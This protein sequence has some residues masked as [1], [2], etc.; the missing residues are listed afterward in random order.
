MDRARKQPVLPRILALLG[1]S[2]LSLINLPELSAQTARKPSPYEYR[3]GTAAQPSPSVNDAQAPAYLARI[4]SSDDFMRLARIY[5]AGTPLEIP[6]LIFTIDRA[7]PSRIYYIN[8]PRYELHEHFVRRE[9]L[10]QLN[11]ATLNAQYKDPQRRFLFGTLSWQRDLPGYTYEFWEGD[12]LTP[13]L[14]TQT[15]QLIHASF[16][17]AI[18]F[19]TNS[20]LHEQTARSAALPFVTQEALLREQRFLPLNTGRAQGRLRIVS[21]TERVSDLSPH[22][23]VVLDEV[24][25]ALPPIAGLVTQRPSTLLSH[26]NLLA[27][28]WRIPNAYVHNAQA[29]LRQYDGQWVELEVTPNNYRVR[30]IA[31]PARTPAI[32]TP[33]PARNLPRPDLSVTALQPLSALR[34]RDSRHCGVKAA[35]LGTLKSA[36]PPAA[37]VPDG[38]CVPFSQYQAAMLRLQ[39]PQRLATLQQR[40]GFATDAAVRRNALTTLRAEISNAA[41]DPALSHLLQAQWQK[42]LQGRGVFVRSSSNSEDL[43]GFSGAGLYTTVPNVTRGDALVRAI[44]AV[45]ASVYNFE[46]Y[47]AR[48]A[49]GLGQ[50][51]VAMAVLVQLAAPSDS[52][53][54]MITRDPFDAGRRHIT[55]ISAKR[56]LGI[57]VVEGK[58]QAEQVMYSNWSKAVQVLSR[59]AED[60]QLVADVNGGVRE[61]ALTGSR[62]VL[63]DALITRLAAVGRSTRQALG[64]AEQDIEWAVVGDDIVILQSRPYVGGSNH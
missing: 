1:L 22:D 15:D 44:Q 39:I 59:S 11:K 29:A 8:T 16:Y 40:P 54:V 63:T 3:Q 12:Q 27:K 13:A 5:N 7:E 52:S 46:A 38:F 23:I 43:P 28:G 34:A 56:G 47:E 17:D 35:N 50:D 9:G 10:M 64:G 32:A 37:R 55:Y 61:V 14:L 62:Q 36:L 45:W 2:A 26:V 53:G 33:T 48:S 19:K 30:K 57:R 4:R 18:R 31:R 20:T 6:H 21:S 24:P 25:I 58:R 51:A 60:T 42:Q 41:P 49:A